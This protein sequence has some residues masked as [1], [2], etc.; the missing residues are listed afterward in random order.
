MGRI[1][2]PCKL[3]NAD[4]TGVDA[5]DAVHEVKDCVLVQKGVEGTKISGRQIADVMWEPFDKTGDR[6]GF[7]QAPWDWWVHPFPK[8]RG[9]CTLL[10]A[11]VITK[12]VAMAHLLRPDIVAMEGMPSWGS[13]EYNAWATTPLEGLFG[14]TNMDLVFEAIIVH[15]GLV[16]S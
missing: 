7:C 6:C 8:Q 13:S 1:C 14:W 9:E 3:M 2:I 16:D 4:H 11:G 15:L 12:V 10:Y 5:M